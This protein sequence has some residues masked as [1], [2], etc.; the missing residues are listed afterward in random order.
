MIVTESDITLN[1][2]A[3]NRDDA[4]RL[5]D[6]ELARK[7]SVA[8]GFYDALVQREKE[9]STWI[10]AGVAMPHVNRRNSAL[11]LRSC[12]HILQFPDGV[13]WDKGHVAFVVVVVAAKDNEHIDILAGLASLM[14]DERR[15]E[16]LSVSTSVKEFIEI[17]KS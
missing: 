1:C 2:S 10:G 13:K 5:A 17:L 12:F 14:D 9:L 6:Y 8:A 4:L 7:R 16:R 3:K 11:V 15:V